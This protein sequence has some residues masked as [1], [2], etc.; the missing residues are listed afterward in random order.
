MKDMN[1]CN[2]K[3]D[4]MV[5]RMRDEMARGRKGSNRFKVANKGR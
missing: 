1:G 2:S 5:S 4:P 3:V